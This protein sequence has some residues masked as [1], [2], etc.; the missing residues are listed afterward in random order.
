MRCPLPIEARHGSA[1]PSPP[2]PKPFCGQSKAKGQ[3][4][5]SGDRFGSVSRIATDDCPA[6]SIGPSIVSECRHMTAVKLVVSKS[7]T[8]AFLAVLVMA[9]LTGGCSQKTETPQQLL[10]K[11][12]EAFEKGQFVAAEQ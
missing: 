6:L 4:R 12:N 8:P 7:V 11:A 2:R 10:S 3:I 5:K 1:V 9:T